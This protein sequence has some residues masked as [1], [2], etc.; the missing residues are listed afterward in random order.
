MRR[1]PGREP[2]NKNLA[3]L[4]ARAA[5]HPTPQSV[6]C[7][8][9][10]SYHVPRNRGS[11]AVASIAATERARVGGE[12]PGKREEKDSKSLSAV[13]LAADVNGVT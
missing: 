12:L 2:R 6:C 13:A 11:I 8:A 7:D 4:I 10:E 1:R 9:A 5:R 3:M